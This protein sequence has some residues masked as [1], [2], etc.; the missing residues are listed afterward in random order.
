MAFGVTSLVWSRKSRS[1]YCYPEVR[2]WNCCQL[3]QLPCSK[4]A[5]NWQ[6]KDT[7]LLKFTHPMSLIKKRIIPPAS[8]LYSKIARA[9]LGD[10]ENAK[11]IVSWRRQ[12]RRRKRGW[13]REEEEVERERR[14][15]RSPKQSKTESRINI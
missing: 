9:W 10:A 15:P 12:R 5:R 3:P 14:K 4:K 11:I 7:Y 2:K 13:K 6:E 8:F 1:C